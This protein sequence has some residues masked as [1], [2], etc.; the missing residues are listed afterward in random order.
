MAFRWIYV[1][2]FNILNVSF[3]DNMT[4]VAILI[5]QV[6]SVDKIEVNTLGDKN[7]EDFMNG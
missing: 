4:F 5:C 6:Q 1:F 2:G 3:S 7:S